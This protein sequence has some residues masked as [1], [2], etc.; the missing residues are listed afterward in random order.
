MTTL[1]NNTVPRA[2]ECEWPIH[3]DRTGITFCCDTP[4]EGY[5]Y[6]EKH[7]KLAY[8]TPKDDVLDITEV[9]INMVEIDPL[10]SE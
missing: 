10:E 9:D 7:H 1:T 3:E 6:C 5:S 8:F 2:T 4:K